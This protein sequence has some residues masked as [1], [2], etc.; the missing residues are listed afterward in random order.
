MVSK[1]K[2][3]IRFS[4]LALT[5]SAAASSLVACGGNAIVITR[6][7][8]A[9]T[10][11]PIVCEDAVVY[12]STSCGGACPAGQTRGMLCN[13][14]R[15]GYGV[16]GCYVAHHNVADG[17]GVQPLPA[18]CTT[19]ATRQ[20]ACGSCSSGQ[21]ST[22]TCVNGQWD[23]CRC[24]NQAPGGTP[25]VPNSVTNNSC[26]TCQPGQTARQVCNAAGT[27]YGPCECFGSPSTITCSPNFQRA[28][29]A[30]TEVAC[31]T[32]QVARQTCSNDGFQWSA[33]Q[34][35]STGTTTTQMC[36]PNQDVLGGGCT[37]ASNQVSHH[38]CNSGGTAFNAC[39]CVNTGTTVTPCV[40]GTLGAPSTCT[41]SCGS[42]QT[43][44]Q[45]CNAAGTAYNGDCQCVNNG[46]GGPTTGGTYTARVAAPTNL[47]G[48]C[49][50]V[51][52]FSVVFYDNRGCP[53]GRF[54]AAGALVP[55]TTTACA[56]SSTATNDRTIDFG[57]SWNG[58]MDVEIYCGSNL[59]RGFTSG[60]TA[61]QAGFNVVSVQRSG[62]SFLVDQLD[63]ARTISISK[64]RVNVGPGTL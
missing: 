56:N 48:F 53:L 36:V 40:P 44:R 18:V 31:S 58:Y 3:A 16:C 63:T 23:D 41:S 38:I 42:N 28:C 25:C 49:S 64:L 2:S 34:C 5:V 43:M 22:Q 46:G 12:I 1:W 50:N 51:S 45:Q 39:F 11:A 62:I 21:I 4:L 35:V 24:V 14:E 37:C 52:L 54:D 10:V 19:G 13:A 7:D 61:R 30:G 26:A 27:G 8:A 9:T 47:G 29:P 15:T 59:Y 55:G 33:C 57:D 32:N 20:Q 17:G 60:Q 6:G